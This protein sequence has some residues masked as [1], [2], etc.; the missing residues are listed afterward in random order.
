MKLSSTDPKESIKIGR[1]P[2]LP[3][4]QRR[5]LVSDVADLPFGSA[6]VS[7]DGAT[8]WVM[9]EL[10]V[11]ASLGGVLFVGE[12]LTLRLVLAAIAILGGI[13]LV[14]RGRR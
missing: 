1:S 10:P 8:A 14:I 13:A 12:A 5:V 9:L 4:C 2:G 11:A 3:S 7:Q 6:V